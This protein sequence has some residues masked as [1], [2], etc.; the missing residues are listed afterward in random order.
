MKTHIITLFTLLIVAT[1]SSVRA[2]EEVKVKPA[3]L[4]EAT[5]P[6]DL[7]KATK[8]R[9]IDSVKKFLQAGVNPNELNFYTGQTPLGLAIKNGYSEIIQLFLADGVSSNAK[10]QA[11]GPMISFQSAL[12]TAVVA[13]KKDSVK[14][15]ID[16]G[17]EVN[18]KD[19]DETPLFIAARKL[20]GD[21]E[22]VKLLLDAGADPAI[23]SGLSEQTAQQGVE[24]YK[25]SLEEIPD[26]PFKKNETIRLNTL[27]ELLKKAENK[28]S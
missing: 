8:Q 12:Y 9:N 20:E 10:I 14:T 15:L 22:I 27:I 6:A 4:K 16:A 17:A 2:M 13:N 3:T 11:S 1:G 28:H 23:K 19:D 25:E 24:D 21:L 18:I 5:E 26:S 7:E